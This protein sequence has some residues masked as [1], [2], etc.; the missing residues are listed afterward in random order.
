MNKKLLIYIVAFNH[1]QFIKKV[2]D[3]IDEKNT[4]LKATINYS[5]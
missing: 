2:L 4:V 5:F 3:R 1:E